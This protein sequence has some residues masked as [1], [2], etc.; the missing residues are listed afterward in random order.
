MATGQTGVWRCTQLDFTTSNES[1]LEDMASEE[2]PFQPEL[3]D[4]FVVEISKGDVS[5][6]YLTIQ[7]IKTNLNVL[8]STIYFKIK[9]TGVNT[10]LS[11][12]M[13]DIIGIQM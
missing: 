10:P 1:V 11:E 5:V 12:V 13:Y 3:H 6:H 2:Q 9:P 7:Y 8:G 4:F